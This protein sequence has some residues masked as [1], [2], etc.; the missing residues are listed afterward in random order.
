MYHRI[1]RQTFDPWSMFVEPDRFAAQIEWLAGNRIVLPL[2]EVAR[3]NR[4]RRLP[5]EA[6]ALT[7]DD[8]YAS[9]L[10]AVP[11]L[12][13]HGLHATVFLPTELIESGGRF[14]WDELARLILSSPADSLQLDGVRRPVSPAQERDRSWSPDAAPQT[15]RQRFFL[16]I[17]SELWTRTPAALGTAMTELRGQAPAIEPDAADRALTP[18]QVRSVSPATMSFGSH[19]LTHPCLP[20]LDHEEKLH[21]ISDSRARCTAITGTAPEAFAYP[22]GRLDEA[23]RRLVEQAGYGCGC[24]AGDRFVTKRSNPFA[25]PRL[26]VGNWETADLR[27][28][29]GG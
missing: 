27:D 20:V 24:A 16:A 1:G 21:E 12:Q 18:E 25:L 7:F 2:T 3:L 13:K 22:Y 8:G 17:W 6:V 5:R 28:M 11:L 15:P 23:S 4:E 19:G 26:N 10:E 14:W 29:L 9:V